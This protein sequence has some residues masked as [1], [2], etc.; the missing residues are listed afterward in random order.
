MSLGARPPRL[1][2]FPMPLLGDGLASAT[3]PLPR[4]VESPARRGS[5]VDTPVAST[6]VPGAAAP[7]LSAG[8]APSGS[9]LRGRPAV[10]SLA[11]ISLPSLVGRR[12][13]L[14]VSRVSS[15][16]SVGAADDEETMEER[17]RLSLVD[18]RTP[19]G[20]DEEGR[21]DLTGP[22]PWEAG[23]AAPGWGA[24]GGGVR[25]DG[26]DHARAYGAVSTGGGR[27]VPAWGRSMEEFVVTRELGRGSFGRVMEA[28]HRIDGNKYAIKMLDVE[29][30]NKRTMTNIHREARFLAGIQD[31]SHLVRYYG[32]WKAN[33]KLFIQTELCD[34]TLRDLG[35]VARMRERGGVDGD[36]DA[37]DVDDDDVA[38]A[39]SEADLEP[40]RREG[41]AD[42]AAA[43][44][45]LSSAL[46]ATSATSVSS[47]ASS[48][49]APGRI[50]DGILLLCLRHCL[51]ALTV[52]HKGRKREPSAPAA[53]ERPR[54]FLSSNSSSSASAARA[55]APAPDATASASSSSSSS[56]SA[57]ASA[58][59]KSSTQGSKRFFV[60]L[61]IKPENVLFRFSEGN[62]RS[63]TELEGFTYL[64]KLGDLGLARNVLHRQK[65]GWAEDGGGACIAPRRGGGGGEGAGRRDG[66]VTP[67]SSLSPQSAASPGAGVPTAAEDGV[68]GGAVP[69]GA[70]EEEE[71]KEEEEK[72]EEEEEEEAVS[73]GTGAATGS[74][75]A[76]SGC[77]AEEEEEEAHQG[78]AAAEALAVW[79]AAL[80]AAANEDDADPGTPLSARRGATPETWSSEMP[81]IGLATSSSS[82]GAASPPP[83]GPGPGAGSA[84][85]APW[86]SPSR[87]SVACVLVPRADA[88]RWRVRTGPASSLVPPGARILPSIAREWRSHSSWRRLRASGPGLRPRPGRPSPLRARGLPAPGLLTAKTSATA[89]WGVR[90][91]PAGRRAAGVGP[92]RTMRLRKA[93]ARV[94][95]SSS[96]C[97]RSALAVS[98]ARRAW[99]R[100]TSRLALRAVSIS[101]LASF[102]SLRM[103]SLS[104]SRA[105]GRFRQSRRIIR[106]R[107]GRRSGRRPGSGGSLPFLRA[108][109]TGPLAGSRPF[110]TAISRIVQPRLKTSAAR[111][112]VSSEPSSS[113]AR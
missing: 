75:A 32:S 38:V 103:G 73:P 84:R 30:L 79:G 20:T 46:S 54:P 1:S 80:A 3:R 86:V 14:G 85:R 22:A 48:C 77:A 59:P 96:L 76:L 47:S 82:R 67:P 43:P 81:R 24:A 107:S 87:P 17:R 62:P 55:G 49:A 111:R 99:A 50:P 91:V 72:E 112:S 109:Q 90:V 7:T 41:L 92:S 113:G 4:G 16:A 52:L 66:S 10:V 28:M 13:G 97:R 26:P 108:C 27:V 2:A 83:A 70:E 57:S 65:A 98:S 39:W 8:A 35:E 40:P 33:G 18:V 102:S 105:V 74:G 19:R 31:T 88:H 89:P 12:S 25:G 34:G 63:K 53:A 51:L 45:P 6:I 71:E 64:F 93:S 95:R 110:P 21:A 60:H 58:A 100:L 11:G 104:S 29:G 78:V 36:V 61:D 69:A 106:R 101:L 15:S 5:A 42:A 23:R 94:L 56:S 37:D 68:E 9:T 44:A